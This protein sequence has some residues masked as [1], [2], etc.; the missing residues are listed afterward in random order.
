MGEARE[1]AASVWREL[2]A[3]RADRRRLG[4]KQALLRRLR[5]HAAAEWLH[6]ELESTRAT[7][8]ALEQSLVHAQSLQGAFQSETERL[9]EGLHAGHAIDATLSSRL[10]DHERELRVR[11]VMDWI[12]HAHLATDPLVS[13]ILPTRDRADR[14]GRAI[15]SVL[16]QHYLNVELVIVDDGSR[17]A[18][19][20]RLASYSDSRVRIVQAAGDGVCAARNRG[21]DVATGSII[22][23]LDDDNVMHPE[24]LRSVVWGFEQRPDTNVV[25]GAFVVDDIARVD[26]HGG[27]QLPRL[28]FWPYDAEAVLQNNVADISAIAHRAGL[29]EAH[30]DESLREMGDWDLLL[31]LTRE[32]PPLPLPAIACFYATDAHARLSGGPTNA[33][34]AARVREKNQR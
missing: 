11:S 22:T 33:A 15:D 10:D 7:V 32:Q 25:Y 1:L 13:V 28:C 30:F 19:P 21:L 20:A 18:T 34:D 14:V 3:V 17:D 29:P 2:H 12:A 9:W 4:T 27:G 8:R 31:R 26:G 24:W 16:G 5:Y 23:Y 6:A